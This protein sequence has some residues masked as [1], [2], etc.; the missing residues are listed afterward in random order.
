MDI[1][2]S[3]EK[4]IDKGHRLN[5]SAPSFPSLV[6]DPLACRNALP[7]RQAS[8]GRSARP[9]GSNLTVIPAKTVKGHSRLLEAQKQ[10]N[11][12]MAG[13]ET[14]T[15][16]GGTLVTP[17]DYFRDLRSLCAFLLAYGR[18]VDL[19]ELPC[20]AR[21]RFEAEVE[22]RERIQG[23]RANRRTAGEGWCKRPRMRPYKAYATVP[24][25]AALVAAVAPA[26][27]EV[28]AS[29]SM[30]EMAAKLQPLV[31][32][33]RD[34]IGKPRSKLH[35]LGSS[36]R[37]KDVFELC[38]TPYMKTVNRLS[39][40]AE[41]RSGSREREF[42]L[43]SAN[44]VPQLF[45]PQEFEQS[46]ADLLPG[47]RETNA[48]RLCSMWLV[49]LFEQCTWKEAARRLELPPDA[50]SSMVNKAM[51]LLNREGNAEIFVANLREV[52]RQ[53]ETNPNLVDYGSRRQALADF[54]EI[55]AEQ[56]QAI[57]K[58][59]GMHKGKARGKNRFAAAWIWR[60]LTDGDHR[61]APALQK[62]NWNSER[63]GYHKFLKWHVGKLESRLLEY[64]EELL[65]ECEVS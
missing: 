55:P 31:E 5:S 45:W 1:C 42:S 33:I 29:G 28:L 7:V 32:R 46:F 39:V 60:E 15:V 8:G 13:D 48:R 23:E 40:R 17:V 63:T 22:K 14:V 20:V 12:A 10:L 47:I 41:D 3:C 24:K 51:S 53:L 4:G 44:H 65:A 64:S 57:C 27:I 61:L 49:K 6:P 9:C 30:E 2:P 50:S 56:W 37:V 21:K 54:T 62:A 59:A 19:G 38:L 25:N 11:R 35:Y 26:A 18:I 58:D 43:L 36:E 34:E 16:V 52:A